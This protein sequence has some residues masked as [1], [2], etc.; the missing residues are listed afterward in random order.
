MGSLIIIVLYNQ[1]HEVKLEN[2]QKARKT[3]SL[4]VTPSFQNKNK[5]YVQTQY[6]WWNNNKTLYYIKIVP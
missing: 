5:D 1:R 2:E 4:S 3:C 6:S